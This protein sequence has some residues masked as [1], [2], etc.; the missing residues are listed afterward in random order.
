MSSHDL[1]HIETSPPLVVFSKLLKF[2]LSFGQGLLET[3]GKA[4]VFEPNG[5]ADDVFG[6]EN[7]LFLFFDGRLTGKFFF[8]FSIVLL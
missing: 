8:Y 1:G 4:I 6:Q 7:F 3:F 2:L 5:V